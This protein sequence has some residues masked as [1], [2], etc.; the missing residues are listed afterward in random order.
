MVVAEGTSI[1]MHLG[2]GRN[3]QINQDFEMDNWLLQETSI[4]FL[5]DRIQ[6][7]KLSLYLIVVIIS[8]NCYCL[9]ISSRLLSAY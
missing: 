8:P 6:W 5:A 4:L 2:M 1:G 7:L 9:Q 3:Y